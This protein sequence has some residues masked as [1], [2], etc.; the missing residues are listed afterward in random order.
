MAKNK[1]V[2]L[3]A[4]MTGPGQ[5][6]LREFPKPQVKPEH[7]L[8]RIKACA[9]CTWEQR[10][11]AGLQ[12]AGFP[13]VGGHEISGEIEAVGE[14]VPSFFKVGDQVSMLETYCGKCEWCR[15]GLP[16]LCSERPGTNKYMDVSGS[17]GFSQYVNLHASAVYRFPRRLANKK[18]VFFEPLAC[19]VHAARQAE[20]RLAEDVVIIGGGPMGMLNLLAAK[21][22][23]ARVILNEIVEQRLEKGRKLGADELVDASKT[24]PVARVLE[25]TNGKGA[26]VVI[27]AVGLGAANEQAVKMVANYGRVVLFSS[28]H[29]AKPVLL[30]PNDIHHREFRMMG[31]VSKNPQDALIASRMLAYGLIDPSPLIDE[32]KPMS[33][34]VSAMQRAIEPD[35]YRVI[36]EPF[37]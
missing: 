20:I 34:I 27:V 32:V 22:C 5:L 2:M 17:W 33:D 9:I 18:A 37:K 14:G 1:E 10:V 28:A 30:D 31:A 21:K 23:G 8:V 4:V 36:V 29:P 24:D 16:N 3:A 35:S 25:L 11:F 13:L 12:K 15:R 19:A 6:E 26:D 7:I